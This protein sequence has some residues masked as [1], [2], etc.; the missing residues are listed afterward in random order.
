MNISYRIKRHNVGVRQKRDLVLAKNATSL[1][2]ID[3]KNYFDIVLKLVKKHPEY[4]KYDKITNETLIIGKSIVV[5]L[6]HSDKDYMVKIENHR[7]FPSP[8]WFHETSYH[9]LISIIDKEAHRF[10]RKLL[11]EARDNKSEVINRIKE[12]EGIDD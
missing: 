4:I 10:R 2:N 8:Q 3:Q 11:K 7:D 1:M 6:Y 9:Y 5:T 12:I